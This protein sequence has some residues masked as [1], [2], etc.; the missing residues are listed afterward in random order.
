MDFQRFVIDS[1][2]A[3]KGQGHGVIVKQPS[4]MSDGKD[5]SGFA[6]NPRLEF[7]VPLNWVKY[8]EMDAFNIC[9]SVTRC[10]YSNRQGDVS[11]LS[12]IF[13]IPLQTD[14]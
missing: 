7:L 2:I 1:D 11:T 5:K 10:E 4:K 9:E 12:P 3:E 8:S 14:L 6:R 13:T